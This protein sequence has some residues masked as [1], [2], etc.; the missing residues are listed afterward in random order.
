MLLGVGLL[1]FIGGLAALCFVRLI[2]VALLGEPRSHG[3]SHAHESSAWMTVPMA[4][5]AAATILAAVVPAHLLRVLAPVAAQLGAPTEAMGSVASST[6]VLGVSAAVIWA[7]LGGVAPALAWTLRGR[8]REAEQTWGCGYLAPTAR[9]QYTARSFTEVMAE[10]LMPPLFRARVAI[11]P[12]EGLFPKSGELST[13]CSDPFTRGVY[14]P[15]LER[16]ARRF[17]RLRWLQQGVLHV[18]ILYILVVVVIALAWM[19]ARA[20]LGA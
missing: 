4:L 17:S 15:F 14:E 1:A 9:M 10:R 12:P 8:A 11:K 16:W 7:A 18:Y 3:A 19:T 5:L 2:G 13:E 6:R 20:W